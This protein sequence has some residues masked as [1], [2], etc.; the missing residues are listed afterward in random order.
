MTERPQRLRNL[1]PESLSIY[2]RF[3]AEI[4]SCQYRED[5]NLLGAVYNYQNLYE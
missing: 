5:A 3:G 2:R 4:D 1:F